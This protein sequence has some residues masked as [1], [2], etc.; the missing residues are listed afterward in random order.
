MGPCDKNGGRDHTERASRPP[1]PSYS[2]CS[3]A[4][5][6]LRSK[7]SSG[8]TCLAR[9]V[10]FRALLGEPPELCLGGCPRG[11]PRREDDPPIGRFPMEP[12]TRQQEREVRAARNQSLFRAVNEQMRGL[13]QVFATVTETFTIACECADT[14][15]L[16]KLAAAG[17]VAEVMAPERA[18][19]G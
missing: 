8:Y 3:Y 9:A 19:S 15:C 18:A 17:A 7:R 14:S 1:V 6:R 4:L 11:S 10:S 5:A 2:C 16:E 13:D 12:D